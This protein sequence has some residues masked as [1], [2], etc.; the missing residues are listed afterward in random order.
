MHQMKH[1]LQDVTAWFVPVKHVPAEPEPEKK[2]ATAATPAAAKV[3]VLTKK[4]KPLRKG[5]FYFY[6]LTQIYCS[7]IDVV[8]LSVPST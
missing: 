6:E 5:R 8:P 7:L 1:V 3:V 2:V 4:R